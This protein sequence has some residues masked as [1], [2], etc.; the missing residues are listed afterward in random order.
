MTTLVKRLDTPMYDKV[1]L[2]RTKE[3]DYQLTFEYTHN[4]ETHTFM[5]DGAERV[6]D[7]LFYKS[8]D[9]DAGLGELHDFLAILHSE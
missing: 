6:A 8:S 7:A 9:F 1:C 5:V 4:H 2:L 3:G